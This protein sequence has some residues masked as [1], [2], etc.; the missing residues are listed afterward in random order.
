[1]SEEIDQLVKEFIKNKSKE[2]GSRVARGENL[3]QD[4][5]NTLALREQ[6]KHLEFTKETNHK[7]LEEMKNLSYLTESMLK[8]LNTEV[9]EKSK[10]LES[11]IHWLIF[12][13][14]SSFGLCAIILLRILKD[15]LR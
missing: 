13:L 2:I 11:K 15:L 1:M 8:H 3:T 9:I 14:L 4:D 12:W 10:R 5:M 6:L 7:I